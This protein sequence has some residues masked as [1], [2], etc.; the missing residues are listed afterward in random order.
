MGLSR[1]WPEA[2]EV[3]T[4]HKQ[5]DATAILAYFA[6]L[7][8]WLNEQNK[9]RPWMVVWVNSWNIRSCGHQTRVAGRPDSEPMGLPFCVS[10][11]YEESQ[12]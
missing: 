2:L 5:M 12:A 4:G 10:S 6:P 11:A 8:R 7:Q 1:P 3:V 9:G